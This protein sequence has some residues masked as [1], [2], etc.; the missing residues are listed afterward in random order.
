M[1]VVS[2]ISLGQT[3]T[4]FWA[5]PQTWMPPSADQG[6]EPLAG[7]HRAGRVG[8]EQHHLADGVRPR[9]SARRTPRCS[10]AANSASVS[11]GRVTSSI[12]EILRAGLQAAAA[13]HALAQRIGHAAAAL[14]TAAGRGPCRSSRRPESRPGASPALETA[15]SDRPPGRGPRGTCSSAAARSRPGCSSSSLSTRAVQACRTRPLMTIVQAPQTSS[16]QLQSQ[17]TG[18]TRSPSTVVGLRGDPLQHADH[19]HVGLVLDAM[20]L[21]IARLAR[22]SPAAGR[23]RRTSRRLRASR[24]VGVRVAHVRNRAACCMVG[25]CGRV[26]SVTA[27]YSVYCWA[28]AVRRLWR[29]ASCRCRLV[30]RGLAACRSF[31]TSSI[32]SPPTRP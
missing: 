10:R 29:L 19:V 24:A 7:V 6:V 13:A 18:A 26:L 20:P 23:G 28:A 31:Q 21:P 2:G 12:F 1:E 11:P 4:Q 14:A 27:D 17:A 32:T 3:A 9:R 16:R 5:L 22:A 15:A 25:S 30:G 8:V